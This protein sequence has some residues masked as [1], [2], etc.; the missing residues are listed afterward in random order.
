MQRALE[1]VSSSSHGKIKNCHVDKTAN[2]CEGY[3]RRC[4]QVTSVTPGFVDRPRR[5]DCTAGQMDGE[6]GWWTT[7]GNIGLPP[8]ARVMGVCRQQQHV[9]KSSSTDI[10]TV[11]NTQYSRTSWTTQHA[12]L[13]DHLASSPQLIYD[14]TTY[15]NKTNGLSPTTR[16]L[17][18]QNSRK[19][20]SPLSLRRPY[21]LTYTMPT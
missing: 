10:T 2:W 3:H 6:A 11:S 12:L 17:T 21:P 8:L 1:R 19:T 5:S 13:S 16:K 14:M 20:Q 15:Y 18:G 9:N 4:K 7:N